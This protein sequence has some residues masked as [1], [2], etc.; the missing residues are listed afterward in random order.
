MVRFTFLLLLSVTLFSC[1][2]DEEPLLSGEK[3]LQSADYLIFGRYAGFCVGEECV[4]IFKL[5]DNVLSEDINDNYPD[6]KMPYN[7]N[8]QPL[9]SLKML[10]TENILTQTPASI[11]AIQD[12]ILG[13]PDCADGGGVYFEY[14]QGDVRRYWLIDQIKSNIPE[15]IHPLVDEINAIVDT[16]NE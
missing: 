15:Q 13:C 6:Y 1:N 2:K 9:T 4:E 8:F 11:F 12:T 7:G 14:K 16:I 3:T 5:E 10:D